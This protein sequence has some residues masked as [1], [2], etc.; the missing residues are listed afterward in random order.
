METKLHPAIIRGPRL[1][2]QITRLTELQDL[3]AAGKLTK[4]A[5]KELRQLESIVRLREWLSPGDT[6]FGVV[7]NVSRSGMSREIDFFCFRPD[8]DETS[9][10]HQWYLSPSIGEA[11]GIRRADS[12]ALKIGGCGMDM[13][14]ATVYS[15]SS[16]AYPDGFIPGKCGLYGRNGSP[17]DD[18]DPDGGY[19]LRSE[20]L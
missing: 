5:D 6:V 4:K 8:G 11:L 16:A 3:E 19:A 13:I 18:I 17:A 2:A 15:L 14:F 20:S 9:G 1:K 7:R 10:I 12:G